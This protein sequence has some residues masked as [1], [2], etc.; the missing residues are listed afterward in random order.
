MAGKISKAAVN[1]V[2]KSAI[3]GDTV[4]FTLKPE[5]MKPKE[6]YLG[7]PDGREF[8]PTDLSKPRTWIKISYLDTLPHRQKRV[9]LAN[10]WHVAYIE[11]NS[12]AVGGLN[13][14]EY[15]RTT[16]YWMG[17]QRERFHAKYLPYI[18]LEFDEWDTIYLHRYKMEVPEFSSGD[19]VNGYDS[20]S[21]KYCQP[22]VE[23]RFADG[24]KLSIT[25]EQYRAEYGDDEERHDDF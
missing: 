23:V 12:E 11:V 24:R 9:P 5:A 8:I 1:K 18:P 20:E 19:W 16:D 3:I 2:T 13:A 10:T 25:Y 22:N 7:F 6:D 4:S 14:S 21:G 17:A 15:L